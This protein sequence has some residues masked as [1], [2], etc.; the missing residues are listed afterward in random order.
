MVGLLSGYGCATSVDLAVN[1]FSLLPLLPLLRS[2]DLRQRIP[3]YLS[4]L[5]LGLAFGL[6]AASAFGIAVS[7]SIWNLRGS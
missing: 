4:P 2:Y 5:I 3:S 7:E 6:L 1:R